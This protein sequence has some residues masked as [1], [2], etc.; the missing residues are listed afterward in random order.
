LERLLGEVN[1]STATLAQE[2]RTARSAGQKVTGA[3]SDL[4]NTLG[5]I[6]STFARVSEVNQI[7]AEI[8]DRTNLLALNAAIEAAR[9]GEHGRG[10]AIVAQE[11]GKLAENNAQNAKSIAEII[12]ESSRMIQEGAQIADEAQQRVGDQERS[13]QRVDEFFGSLSSRIEAQQAIN[14]KLVT[15]LNELTDL[16]KEIEQLSKEQSIGTEGVTKT[17]AEMESGVTG[18]VRQSTEI[19]DSL[20]RIKKMAQQLQE[21]SSDPDVRQAANHGQIEER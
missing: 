2:V 6:E 7:M 14:R 3:V 20:G 18:L 17:I 1:G 4:N 15:A 12:A 5:S 19:A 21:H 11:V 10:F 16:S 8:A 9:A 13:I